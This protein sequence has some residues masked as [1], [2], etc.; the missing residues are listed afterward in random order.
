MIAHEYNNVRFVTL[1]ARHLIIL[2]VEANGEKL[3]K[4]ILKKNRLCC[5]ELK[6]IRLHFATLN[7]AKDRNLLAVTN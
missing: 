4:I 5:R 6:T 1:R 3:I 7:F 2:T